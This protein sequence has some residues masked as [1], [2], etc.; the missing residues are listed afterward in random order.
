M[1]KINLFLDDVRQPNNVGWNDDNWVVVRTAKEA[2]E[3]LKQGN[4]VDL[5]LDH[6][7][8]ME[9]VE[10]PTSMTMRGKYIEGY[11]NYAPTGYDLCKWMTQE[12]VWPSG[13][14]YIHSSNV[15]GR[16]AMK[17]LID[18]YRPEPESEIIIHEDF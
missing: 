2:F 16:I 4:V 12:N 15:P 18:R 11:N 14:I 10:H 6:D 9:I 1:N 8:G 13:H 17:Q 7:L 3:I 5:S